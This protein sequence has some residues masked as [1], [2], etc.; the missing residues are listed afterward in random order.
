LN[1]VIIKDSIGSIGESA[2]S[3]CSNLALF[4]VEGSV[5]TIGADAFADC[6]KLQEF[7]VASFSGVIESGTFSGCT[8]LSSCLINGNVFTI[9]A[10]AFYNCYDMSSLNLQGIKTIKEYAMSGSGLTSFTFDDSVTTIEQ[11]AF[12]RCSALTSLVIPSSVIQIG[13]YAF[14]SS[15]GLTSIEYKGVRD[16]GPYSEGVFDGCQKLKKVIVPTNYLDEVFCGIS[17]TKEG[18]VD[19]VEV[20]SGAS[21]VNGLL[22]RVITVLALSLVLLI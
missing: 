21:G 16:P 11:Y 12:S 3:S 9:G 22:L 15:T 10:K 13:N 18:T 19:P 1:T 6:N 4:R 7:N 2:F 17:V 8:K 5:Q 20:V 14:S